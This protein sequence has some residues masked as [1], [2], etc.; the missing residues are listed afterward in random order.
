MTHPFADGCPECG[1]LTGAQPVAP[2]VI[3][4]LDPPHVRALYRCPDCGHTWSTGWN[5]EFVLG[6]QSQGGAA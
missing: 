4:E 5:T 3:R 1:Y 6:Q 2:H